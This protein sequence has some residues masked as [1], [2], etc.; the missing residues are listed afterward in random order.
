MPKP[1]NL[2]RSF[3][4][5]SLISIAVI[6][7]VAALLLSR[8]MERALVQRDAIVTAELIQSI[9]EHEE[10]ELAF[11]R[12]E[13]LTDE[14]GLGE[15]FIH[16]TKI[17]DVLRANVFAPDRSIVWSNDLALVGQRFV[18]NDELEEALRGEM[19]VELGRVAKSTKN[20][21]AFFPDGVTDFVENYVPIWA[22]D[23][24]MVV[25]VV[26]IYRTP[27]ALFETIRD[28]T[29]LV[30]SIALASGV[31]L[32][33]TLF[34]VVHRA[35]NV[36]RRQHALL[37]ESETMVAVGEM[38]T[39]VA[40]GI[41]NPLASIRSSAELALE[42]ETTE[43]GREATRDVILEVDRIGQW[44]REMLLFARPERGELFEV[45]LGETVRR[46][47]DNFQRTMARQHIRS[48]VHIADA[49]PP[50]K[51]DAQLLTQMFNS[52]IANAVEA[53]PNGGSLDVRAALCHEGK[54]LEMTL[55]D[56]GAGIPRAHLDQVLKPFFTSKRS[57]LGIGLQLVKRIVER[58]GGRIVL[59]S[60][61]G[62][63]TTVTLIYPV[64]G[65]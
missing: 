8:F 45:D 52:I 18:D 44:L 10:P 2:V 59:S 1:T 62:Q 50:V 14:E 38:A 57:G 25:G 7:S 35:A 12:P 65:A 47:L 56:T 21:H 27:V 42:E 39:A 3:A 6:C 26:E 58:H 19:V 49:L 30:W 31:F 15:L 28:G 63:G 16:I 23:H 13:L 43:I 61:E 48:Q 17:P 29:W 32:Y 55:S 4:L 41:R 40:H 60:V 24:S 51:G 22:H 54:E 34:W 33:T 46:S 9:A 64:A 20:E 11:D 37:V 5:L 36:M 53:M